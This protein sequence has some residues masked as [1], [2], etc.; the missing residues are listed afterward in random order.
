M[1]RAFEMTKPSIGGDTI[2]CLIGKFLRGIYFKII[3][4]RKVGREEGGRKLE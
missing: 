3:I 4:E 2:G 1:R